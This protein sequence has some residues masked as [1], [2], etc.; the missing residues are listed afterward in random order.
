MKDSQEEARVRRTIRRLTIET[1][2]M[3]GIFAAWRNWQAWVREGGSTSNLVLQG[4]FVALQ[5]DLMIRLIR[6]L[7][8]GADTAS[9]WYLHRSGLPGIEEGIDMEF[10]KAFSMKLM[11]IR[12]KVFVHIDKQAVFAPEKH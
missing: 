12:N 2:N 5:S 1:R 11:K 3:R 7:D 9:F 8:R 4:A 10:L 6:V